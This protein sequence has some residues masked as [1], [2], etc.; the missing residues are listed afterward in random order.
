MAGKAKTRR[1]SGS[2]AEGVKR[3]ECWCSCPVGHRFVASLYAAV[4]LDAQP[5]AVE[6]LSDAGL[7]PARCAKCGAD[8]WLAEPFVLLLPGRKRS[9]LFVPDALAHREL[10]LRSEALLSHAAGP[11][12]DT[13]PYAV[14]PDVVVGVSA[15]H[16]WLFGDAEAE[17]AREIHAAFKDLEDPELPSG[18]PSL[19]PAEPQMDGVDVNEPLLDEDWLADDA[20]APSRHR[21]PGAAGRRSE[22]GHGEPA[23]PRSARPT[24][25]EGV[26]FAGLLSDDEGEPPAG[27]H[28]GK[29]P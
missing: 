16:R 9:A 12:F 1:E 18:K 5:E 21:G 28:R 2:P 3:R 10:E 15:L 25:H 17:P 26:D 14:V 19:P 11:A 29:R 22:R 8:V 13:P 4:D 7:Q 20:I 6:L 23:V 24:P 27:K